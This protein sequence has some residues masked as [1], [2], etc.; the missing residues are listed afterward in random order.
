VKA[1]ENEDLT[2]WNTV[3]VLCLRGT[4]LHA[5]NGKVNLVL[6]NPRQPAPGGG[7]MPLLRGRLQI[8][9]EGAEVF[10]RNIKVRPITTFPEEYRSC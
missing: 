10:Y 3:D 4:C 5:V 6:T 1:F 8:Q 7:T 2:G 9:S